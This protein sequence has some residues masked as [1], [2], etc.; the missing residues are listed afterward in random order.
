[1]AKA[2]HRGSVRAVSQ[3][4]TPRVVREDDMQHDRQAREAEVL[5]L[6]T[7]AAAEWAGSRRRAAAG[8]AH[9]RPYHPRLAGWKPA[10]TAAVAL[11]V[12]LPAEVAAVFH[13]RAREVKDRLGT[14]AL[15]LTPPASLHFTLNGGPEVWDPTRD[16][17]V[18][19]TWSSTIEALD[20]VT[21]ALRPFAFRARG[22]DPVAVAVLL[23]GI[24]GDLEGFASIQAAIWKGKVPILAGNGDSPYEGPAKRG[25]DPPPVA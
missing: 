7:R 5:A 14:Q 4:A 13:E 19:E 20:A 9:S 10:T 1:M 16:P 18:I 3:E 23:R 8:L 15:D 17:S 6:N 25:V 12:R 2:M 24:G 22:F 21:A 11:M